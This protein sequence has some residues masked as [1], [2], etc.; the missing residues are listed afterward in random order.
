MYSTLFNNKGILALRYES[1]TTFVK[2]NK[3]VTNIDE[4]MQIM[5]A[6]LTEITNRFFCKL[7]FLK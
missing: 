1:E 6:K 3:C 4:I 7:T 5:R 2:S